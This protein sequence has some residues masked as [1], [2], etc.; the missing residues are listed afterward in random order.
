MSATPEPA[1]QNGPKKAG[2]RARISRRNRA[3]GRMGGYLLPR[4]QSMFAHMKPERVERIGLWLGSLHYRMDAKHRE[5]ALSNLA[6]AFPELGPE[7]VTELAK[8]VFGHF[9]RSM[10]DFLI[11][12]RRTEAEYLASTEIVGAEHLRQALA[13]GKG[14]LVIS[15]H[16][17][18][19]ERI[20]AGVL[21]LGHEISVVVRDAD[22]PVINQLMQSTRSGPGVGIISRGNA[23]RPIIE[24]LRRNEIVAILPDQNSD[25]HF[26]EFFGKPAGTALGPGVLHERT[27]APMVPSYCV[28]VAPCRYRLVFGPPL[29]AGPENAVRGDGAIRAVHRWLESVIREYPDQWLWY[30]DRWK[31][32]RKRGM[33]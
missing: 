21:H 3:L 23:A 4:L 33:L 18:N 22:D 7:Q 10:A 9:G 17:G 24:A 32:A 30:H 15:G 29:Q 5:R 25:E 8:R 1:S 6:M 16:L 26:V 12:S 13:L 19:W 14:A 27:G 28:W 31:S 20:P 2:R 11:A